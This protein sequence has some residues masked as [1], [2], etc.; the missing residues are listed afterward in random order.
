MGEEIV[1]CIAVL[2]FVCRLSCRCPPYKV[3]IFGLLGVSDMVGFIMTVEDDLKRIFFA[4]ICLSALLIPLHSFASEETKFTGFVSYIGS[5][6]AS[7]ST[8][9]MGSSIR[10]SKFSPATVE[11]AAV[12]IG[13][14]GSISGPYLEGA[15]SQVRALVS[16]ELTEKD[17]ASLII[18]G[19]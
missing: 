5:V 17:V 15:V 1:A 18:G 11:D 12:F 6:I 14:E 2:E 7:E 8:A 4:V 16:L 13:S 10:Y 19:I 3:V 9:Q